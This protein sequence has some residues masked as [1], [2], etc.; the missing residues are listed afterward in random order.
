MVVQR[1]LSKYDDKDDDCKSNDDEDHDRYDDG[2]DVDEGFRA[3]HRF[4]P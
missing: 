2:V 1:R 3:G 4:P